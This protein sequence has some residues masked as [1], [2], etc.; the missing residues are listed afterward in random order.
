M[1][2]AQ[3][4]SP[5][6]VSRHRPVRGWADTLVD[7]RADAATNPFPHSKPPL[8]Y[9]TYP[10]PG[11]TVDP[12]WGL[13][14]FGIGSTHLVL[15]TSPERLRAGFIFDEP[16][17]ADD[18]ET[19][20][21]VQSVAPGVAGLILGE[22]A[23]TATSTSA[24][25]AALADTAW[26]NAATLH[27]AL[28][29]PDRWATC[30]DEAL[31]VPGS[32]AERDAL[33]EMVAWASAG[34]TSRWRVR[35]WRRYHVNTPGS[36]WAW[37]HWAARGCSTERTR[38]GDGDA[39]IEAEAPYCRAYFTP[40]SG[41]ERALPV[42]ALA[43]W[44]KMLPLLTGATR[45]RL[46][47]LGVTPRWAAAHVNALAEHGVW[48]R[49]LWKERP[50]GLADEALVA[51]ALARGTDLTVPDAAAAAL[52]GMSAEQAA[53]AVQAGLSAEEAV[54]A[55]TSGELDGAAFEALKV[56]AGLRA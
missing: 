52:A 28:L 49:H 18:L 32:P 24:L 6:T 2:A 42:Q 43:A 7:L 36:L 22:H 25:R 13:S 37:R 17:G 10:H 26:G 39:L 3:T 55:H 33:A 23:H 31:P 47:G 14:H 8:R 34:A 50:N 21:T 16:P 48:L 56:I 15:L 11:S 4:P 30:R 53:V 29:D 54:A 5:A 45:D 41:K 38:L 46:H 40:M 20:Q 35:R 51:L 9:A 27:A 1:T 19:M 44:H 12:G